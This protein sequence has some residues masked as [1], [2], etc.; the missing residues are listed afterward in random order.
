MYQWRH[1]PED[2]QIGFKEL[3]LQGVTQKY[4]PDG[5]SPQVNTILI[6]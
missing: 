3:V 1:L 6:E 2:L 4:I 5:A